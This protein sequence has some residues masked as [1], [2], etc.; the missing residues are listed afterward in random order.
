MNNE[1]RN[2]YDISAEYDNSIIIIKELINNIVSVKGEDLINKLEL[3]DTEGNYLDFIDLLDAVIGRETNK[4]YY[5]E[6]QDDVKYYGLEIGKVYET[7][8]LNV[9]LQS[10][11][12]IKKQLKLQARS[13]LAQKLIIIS[14]ELKELFSLNIDK[15]D[16]TLITLD[17]RVITENDVEYFSN[18]IKYLEILIDQTG[19][20]KILDAERDVF[21]L[22]K[23]KETYNKK[24]SLEKNFYKLFNKESKI[25]ENMAKG[26]R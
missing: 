6:T 10:K 22:E 12:N 14:K 9:E 2:F 24:S 8:K 21:A 3:I 11:I 16:G 19:R 5:C 23:A 18:L 1:V 26:K 17:S 4:Y 20:L 13:I 7:S 15:G 25:I